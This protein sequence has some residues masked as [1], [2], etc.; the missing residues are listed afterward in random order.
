MTQHTFTNNFETG[1]IFSVSATDY[2]FDLMKNEPLKLSVLAKIFTDD[3]YKKLEELIKSGN[4]IFSLNIFEL[5]SEY[6][7][8]NCFL[9][10]FA[11]R[12]KKQCQADAEFRKFAASQALKNES[13]D[14][15]QRWTPSHKRAARSPKPSLYKTQ[16]NFTVSSACH[17]IALKK[18]RDSDKKAKRFV[19]LLQMLKIPIS[20]NTLYEI[21][22][23][24][25]IQGYISMYTKYFETGFNTYPGEIRKMIKSEEITVSSYDNSY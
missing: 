17:I 3:D 20:D 15:I 4:I 12:T 9:Q 21:N 23:D 2:A 22:E 13:I 25:S 8:Y 24:N 6:L 18:I 11:E 19:K 10:L 7:A 1:G 5:C 14:G 16:W